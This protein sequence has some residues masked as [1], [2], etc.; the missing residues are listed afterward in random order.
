MLASRND[1]RSADWLV[2]FISLKNF[3]AKNTAE[4]TMMVFGPLSKML[5]L[6]SSVTLA[7]M[8]TNFSSSA[9]N[10]TSPAVVLVFKV[11]LL[12]RTK[13]VLISEIC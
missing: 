3:E 13:R 10:L 9:V 12:G 8:S 2:P 6:F 1:K 7:T 4:G 5:E 11:S